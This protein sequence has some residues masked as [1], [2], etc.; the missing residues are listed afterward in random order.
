MENFFISFKNSKKQKIDGCCVGLKMQ[1]CN[2]W[3][4]DRCKSRMF[5]LSR[6]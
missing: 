5:E 3:T 2:V 1:N 4:S 6:V